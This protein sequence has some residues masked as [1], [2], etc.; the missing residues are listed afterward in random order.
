MYTSETISCM[1]T[2]MI[3][4][5]MYTSLVFAVMVFIGNKIKVTN[6][7]Y[8]YETKEIGFY[9]ADGKVMEIMTLVKT[10]FK[11]KYSNKKKH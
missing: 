3:I 11:G 2:L 7:K 8:I 9:K 10:Q 6:T 1:Y 5:S 4:C